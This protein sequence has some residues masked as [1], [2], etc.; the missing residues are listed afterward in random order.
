M[1]G[2][3]R[4]KIALKHV[5]LS[6]IVT[7]SLLPLVSSQFSNKLMTMFLIQILSVPGL[8]LHVQQL[9][10]E[11]SCYEKEIMSFKKLCSLLLIS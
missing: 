2:L 10:P 4:S 11:V 7:L 8:I 5:S 3:G 9:S 1:K 6:A